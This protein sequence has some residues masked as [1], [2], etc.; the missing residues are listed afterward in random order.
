MDGTITTASEHADAV[1]E[2]LRFDA[3]V[4]NANADYN[5]QMMLAQKRHM[6]AAE[7]ERQLALKQAL[8]VT[9]EKLQ[10]DKKVADA[11]NKYDQELAVDLLRKKKRAEVNVRKASEEK[12]NAD[13]A[14]AKAS[15]EAREADKEA[16]E[17]EREAKVAT[18]HA[19]ELET[20]EEQKYKLRGHTRPKKKVKMPLSMTPHVHLQALLRYL[21]SAV[22]KHSKIT[23]EEK[24][25][26]QSFFLK[27]G[28]AL[29]SQLA[30]VDPDATWHSKGVVHEEQYEMDKKQPDQL[31]KEWG[32]K[33]LKS[34]TVVRDFMT[35]VLSG[36]KSTARLER[37]IDQHAVGLFGSAHLLPLRFKNDESKPVFKEPSMDLGETDETDT[38]EDQQTPKSKAWGGL[39]GLE[40]EKN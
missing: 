9:Q 19:Q 13:R 18:E 36:K 16:T 37:P 35:D 26:M 6:E 17:A 11:Q 39:M 38:S 22:T 23:P 30:Q 29:L 3:K 5:K 34:D 25:L 40:T 15:T 2:R 32:S 8:S 12:R 10:M 20:Q 31:S 1:V 24:E 4:A 14:A 28:S 7:K 27:H 33:N 21:R